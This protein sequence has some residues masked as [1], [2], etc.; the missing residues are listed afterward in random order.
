MIA[1]STT[2]LAGAATTADAIIKDRLKRAKQEAYRFVRNDEPNKELIKQLIKYLSLF[3]HNEEGKQ[4]ITRLAL[5]LRLS[6]K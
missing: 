4:L 1:C 6:V 2:C 3:P 5:K